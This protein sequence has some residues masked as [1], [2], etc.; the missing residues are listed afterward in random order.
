MLL[1]FGTSLNIAEVLSWIRG[2]GQDT[3]ER[4]AWSAN[5]HGRLLGL[6]TLDVRIGCRHYAGPL[7][8]FIR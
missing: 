2:W 3:V 8:I 7:Q 6:Y 5:K 1:G 4:N